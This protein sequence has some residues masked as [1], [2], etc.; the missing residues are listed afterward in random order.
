MIDCFGALSLFFLPSGSL[1]SGRVELI[2]ASPMP[3]M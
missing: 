2:M 3:F 1:Q